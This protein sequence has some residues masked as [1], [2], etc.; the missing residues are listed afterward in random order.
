VKISKDTLKI[1]KNYKNINLSYISKSG[2]IIR[3]LSDAKNIYAVANVDEEFPDFAIYDLKKFLGIV[4]LFEEPDFTFHDKYLTVSTGR[5]KTKYFFSDPTVLTVKLPDKEINISDVLVEFMLTVD[6][7]SIINSVADKLSLPDLT[8]QIINDVVVAVVCDK[9][10]SASNNH[11]IT[12]DSANLFPD[13]IGDIDISL[14]FKIENL[15]LLS[16]DYWVELSKKKIS[17][18]TNQHLDLT[19]YIAMEATSVT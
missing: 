19:Y 12:L 14:N 18:F 13:V 9:S 11:I 7:I 2:N 15:K 3:T 5:Q 6:D 10:T 8:V 4:D 1:L 16:G 17:K